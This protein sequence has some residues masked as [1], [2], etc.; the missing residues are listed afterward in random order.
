VNDDL[1]LPIS[2]LEHHMYC[3]RQCA[4]IHVDGLWED[5]EHTVRG[6]RGHR[7]A[8]APDDSRRE[9]RKR[10]LRALAIW[11]ERLGLTGRAD[12]VEVEPDGRLF[13]VEYKIGRRHGDAAHIQLCAEA[14]CLEEMFGV[15]VPS[16][17]LWLSGPRRRLPVTFD[18]A[19]RITTLRMIDEVRASLLAPGLPA[20]IDDPRCTHCQ[21]RD[22]CLPE[23]TAHPEL[24]TAYVERAV[25]N[26]S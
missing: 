25:W 26:A 10:V 19:L 6:Q 16:G 20:A 24:V 13:P 7:R 5:N 8:D 18:D 1:V 22:A 4:L 11:S 2:A 14:M 3:P 17:G 9:R 12:V 15:E 21:L 23:M